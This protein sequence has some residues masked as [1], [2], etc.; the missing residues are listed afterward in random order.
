MMAMPDLRRAVEAEVEA[1]FAEN[2][3]LPRTEEVTRIL[4]G[5]V[6]PRLSQAATEAASAASKPTQQ[7]A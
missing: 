6:L 5:L 4:W 2:P 7:N 1:V 3:T